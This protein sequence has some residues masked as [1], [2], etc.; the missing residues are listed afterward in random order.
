M[1]QPENHI[2]NLALVTTCASM[3]ANIISCTLTHPIDLIRTRVYFKYYNKN[4]DEQYQGI[5]EA[6][7]KIYQ[8]DGF[9]GYFRG[10]L[11]RI[12]RKGAGT[13]VA[14]GIYEYLVEKKY[15]MIASG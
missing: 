14:W 13:V 5:K 1:A 6:I 12:L 11:P 15:A 8:K 9:F 2:Q 10:L 7:H 3:S 4:K